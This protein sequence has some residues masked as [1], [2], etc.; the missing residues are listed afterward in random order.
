[1]LRA[2]L[3][4]HTYFS[5]D[6]LTSPEKYVQACHKRGI[7]C[8]AVTEHNNIAGALAVE[9]IAPFT[10]I[11]GEEA[12]TAEGEIIGLFLHEEVPGGLSPEETVN[13][14]KEQG[15]LGGG[16]PPPAWAPPPWSRR[17]A[18]SNDSGD[19]EAILLRHLRREVAVAHVNVQAIARL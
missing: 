8:V 13:R 1:M 14:I 10:V 6:A 12:R 3:H 4:T 16:P 18:S 7:N 17:N 5:R 15:G 19:S 11:I 2:D 9:K